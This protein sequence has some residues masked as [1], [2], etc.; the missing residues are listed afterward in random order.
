LGALAHIQRLPDGEEAGHC[1]CGRE[2][3]DARKRAEGARMEDRE[4]IV[5][6]Y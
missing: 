1:S 6:T 4:R 2:M 3:H 5:S